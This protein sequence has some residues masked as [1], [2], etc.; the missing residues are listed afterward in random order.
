MTRTLIGGIAILEDLCENTGKWGL[1]IRHSTID[2]PTN[3]EI[4][5]AA[6][7]LSEQQARDLL[8]Y[9][10]GLIL[11]SQEEIENLFWQTTGEDGPTKLNDYDGPTRIYACT[12]NPSGDLVHENT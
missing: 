11:G 10:Y 8:L 7:Y 5:K 9:D 4:R 3:P 1:Y 12:C 2:A 6:P